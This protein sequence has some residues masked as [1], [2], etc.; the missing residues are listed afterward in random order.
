MAVKKIARVSQRVLK[1][2]RQIVAAV[3]AL[4][5]YNPSN[6]DFTADRLGEALRSMDEAFKAEQL[7]LEQVTKAREEAIKLESQLHELVLGAKR[8]VLAQYGDDSDE[9]TRLGM[10]KK[11]ERRYGRPRKPT[12]DRSKT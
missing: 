11:S 6:S 8:Q 5:D 7:A 3:L 12:T 10:K 4:T 1:K 9:I 2:D